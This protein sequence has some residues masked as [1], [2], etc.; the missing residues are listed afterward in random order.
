MERSDTHKVCLCHLH[1]TA[2]KDLLRLFNDLLVNSGENVNEAGDP[3]VMLTAITKVRV[4]LKIIVLPG[5][6]GYLQINMCSHHCVA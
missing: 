6:H 1:C 2:Y 3:Y 5:N 4:M